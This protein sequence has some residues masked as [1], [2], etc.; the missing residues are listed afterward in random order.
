MMASLLGRLSSSGLSPIFTATVRGIKKKKSQRKARETLFKNRTLFFRII[1]GQCFLLVYGT[2]DV[3]SADKIRARQNVMLW[4]TGRAC[5]PPAKVLPT[6]TVQ[7]ARLV[8]N[9]APLPADRTLRLGRR[10][11]TTVYRLFCKRHIS[12]ATRCILALKHT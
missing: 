4:A 5:V 12:M 7:C 1:S 6:V 8:L 2:L 10:S 11:P 3:R 9:H